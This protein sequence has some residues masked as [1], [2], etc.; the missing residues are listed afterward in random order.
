MNLNITTKIKFVDSLINNTNVS[1]INKIG[2]VNTTVNSL[3]LSIKSR[4]SF[5]N[6]LLNNSKFDL[7]TDVCVCPIHNGIEKI[8]FARQTYICV[9]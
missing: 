7:I 1:L 9:V 2:I 3:N 5:T 8:Y 4:I 6:S